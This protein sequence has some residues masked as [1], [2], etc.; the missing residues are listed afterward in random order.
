MFWEAI[1]IALNG[2]ED[3]MIGIIETFRAEFRM[4]SISDIAFPRGVNGLEKFGDPVMIYKKGTP[5]HVRASLI[6][7][8]LIRDRDLIK[9]YE[10][11]QEGEKIRYI[12]L[13]EPNPF[14]S[15]VLAFPTILPKEFGVEQYIDYDTQFEKAFVDPLKIILDCIGWKTEKVSTLE[16]FF[17]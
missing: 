7:N 3:D 17:S 1:D 12:H 10:L 15:D 8:H 11:I 6:Y 13:K 2:T 5:Q 16:G 14:Q 4:S 9:K